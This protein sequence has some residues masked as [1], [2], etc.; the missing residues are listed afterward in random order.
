MHEKEDQMASRSQPCGEQPVINHDA[1][2]ALA[3]NE[4]APTCSECGGVGRGATGREIYPHRPDLYAKHFY[5]CDCGAYVGCHPNSSRALGTP[6]GPATR[7]ARSAAH[8]A[9]D[10]IWKR[11][12]MR[13]SDAYKALAAQLGINPGSCHISWFDA[14]QCARVVQAVPAIQAPSP[15]Q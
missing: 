14:A 5:R 11:G 15:P 6:A 12:K 8:A 7:R 13:R 10:P 2:A 3:L 1:T 9:F 4:F